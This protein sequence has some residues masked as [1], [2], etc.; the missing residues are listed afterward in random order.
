MT[1]PVRIGING[2]G[3]IGRTVFRIVHERDDVEVAVINDLFDNAQLA[4]LLEHDTV[5]GRFP[6][7]V[8]W[9]ADHLHVDGA[10]RRIAGRRDVADIQPRSVLHPESRGLLG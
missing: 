6:G 8:S 5:M 4:Y 1:S 7:E 2:F 9:D 10:Q 3:R